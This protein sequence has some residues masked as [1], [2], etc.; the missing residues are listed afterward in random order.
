M[1]SWTPGPFDPSLPLYLAL[2]QSIRDAVASGTLSTGDPLP[3]HR[4]LSRRLGVTAGTVSRA[5]NLAA[6]WGL[7]ESRVGRGTRIRDP[8]KSDRR[9]R[10]PR[11][12][13]RID[14]GLLLPAPLT[15]EA[16]QNQA[17]GEGFSDLGREVLRRAVSGYAPEMGYPAHRRNA[18]AWLARHGLD[19]PPGQIMITHGAQEAFLLLLTVIARPGE[20]VLTEELSYVGLKSLCS[21]L[22]IRLAPVRM[23]PQGMLPEDLERAVSASGARVLVCCP[24]LHNPTGITTSTARRRRL[25]QVARRLELLVVEDEPFLAL[26]GRRPPSLASLVPERCFHVAS[27]SKY[28]SPSL[29]VAFL[30]APESYLDIITGARHGLTVS[31]SSLQAEVLSRWIEQGLDHALC[32]WQREE[33]TRRTRMARRILGPHVPARHPTSPFLWMPL[34]SAWRASEFVRAARERGVV[35]LDAEQF[36]VGR[37]QAPHCVRLALTTAPGAEDLANALS[38]LRPLLDEGPRAASDP[39]RASMTC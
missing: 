32:R 1:S 2:A 28:V 26:L 10:Y 21:L 7:V 27:F 13:D 14:L 11:A 19:R 9:L 30:S 18:S 16:L 12:R 33:I 4:T 35:L 24:S 6:S 38:S 34:P 8:G 39:A 31:G 25:A 29:R 15:D 17:F 20:T 22:R 23:D 36:A 5:Y 3:P 37:A